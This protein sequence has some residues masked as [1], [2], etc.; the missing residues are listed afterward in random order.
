MKCIKMDYKFIVRKYK[1]K[2]KEIK[3]TENKKT[4]PSNLSYFLIRFQLQ[5]QRADFM[6]Q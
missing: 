6:L 1:V 4:N 5:V 3:T 2:R